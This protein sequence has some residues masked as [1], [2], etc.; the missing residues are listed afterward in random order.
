MSSQSAPWW[1]RRQ[2]QL[3]ELARER[4]PCYVYEADAMEEAARRFCSLDAVTRSFYAIKA[5]PNPEVLR[6]LDRQGLGFE[7]VSRG[8][9]ER[10]FQVLPDLDPGR[11]LFQPNF[12]PV[13]E[14]A[15]AFD[16]GVHVTLDNVN[17]LTEHPTLFADQDLF[18]RVDPGEG[19]GHHQKVRT[20]GPRSKF[21]VDPE[22]LQKMRTAAAQIDASIVGLHAHL[23]SGIRDEQTWAELVDELALL[24]EEMPSVHVLNVGGGLSVPDRT[25]EISLD[26]GT[27]REV[28]AEAGGR[29]GG[30]DLWMEPGRF[31]VARA[32]VLLAEV[33]Q[34]KTKGDVNFVGLETGMNSLLRP[35]LYGA[36]H[37]IVN[38]TRLDQSPTQTADV[39]GPICEAGDVLGRDRRFPPTEPGDVLLI[40]SVGAYGASMANRYN[41]REPAEEIVLPAD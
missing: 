40:A 3:L 9:L 35:S 23:G 27:L 8:E 11:V 25:A 1:E 41:L 19:H 13:E 33:T 12:A 37:E 10:V 22:D 21:G 32:G 17:L 7:C 2:D 14:Y 6:T 29:H 4:S 20:A 39:V 16:R 36:H 15:E 24:G 28:L 38:L 5:N 18:V 31:L 26:L 30:Y 34:T